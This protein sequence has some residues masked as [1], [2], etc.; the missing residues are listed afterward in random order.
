ML[1]KLFIQGHEET[2]EELS[3]RV[4]KFIESLDE[5]Y[6]VKDIKFQINVYG[7]YVLVIYYKKET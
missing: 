6:E 3:E 2:V 4:N 1:I 5:R 7:I